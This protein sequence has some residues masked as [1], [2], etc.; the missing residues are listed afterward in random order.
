MVA[1]LMFLAVAAIGP[2]VVAAPMP[3]SSM[4]GSPIE[5]S[6]RTQ[7]G[8]EVTIAPCPEG[9]CGT[10]SWIVIP[11]E[12]SAQCEQDKAAFGAQMLDQRNPNKALRNRPLV[13]M[14]MMTLKPTNDPLAFT[15]HIYN[16]EDGKSYDGNA[17][18]VDNNNT[19]RLGGGC[20]GSICVVTQ[21]WPRVPPRAGAPDF[22]CRQ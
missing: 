16:S 20:V 14:Q 12:Y 19:L 17:W 4:I 3:L 11:P 10:L 7:N 1:C 21:D 2:P 13:G 22:T 5:G 9:Y 8:T 15:A 18:V 6:W